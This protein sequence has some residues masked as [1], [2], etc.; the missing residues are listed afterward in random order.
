MNSWDG[1]KCSGLDYSVVRFVST[2]WDAREKMNIPV[3]V[4]DENGFENELN[5]MW[6]W[7]W[8]PDG[9]PADHRL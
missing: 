3:T 2:A 6:E 8:L 9:D 4:Y 7:D 1:Y 5:M